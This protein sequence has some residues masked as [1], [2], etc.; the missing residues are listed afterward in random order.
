MMLCFSGI[1]KPYRSNL[2]VNENSQFMLTAVYSHLSA[3]FCVCS[4]NIWSKNEKPF[5]NKTVNI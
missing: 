3:M 2:L 5:S 1:R 4:V